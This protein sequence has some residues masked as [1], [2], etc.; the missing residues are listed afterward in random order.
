MASSNQ[1]D[2]MQDP[3]QQPMPEEFTT[4]EVWLHPS[5]WYAKMRENNPVRY[6]PDRDR[7]D[8]FRYADVNNILRDHEK[9]APT[10]GD[11]NG[12]K[13]MVSE[14]PPEH[15]RL[16]TFASEWFQPRTLREYRPRFEE[17]A[18]EI[19]DDIEPGTV[20]IVSEYTHPYPVIVIAESLGLPVEDYDQ[21]MQWS[22]D[23]LRVPART[24]DE[25]LATRKEQAQAKQEMSQYFS[26]LITQRMNGDGNDNDL[27]TITAMN[28]ELTHEEKVAFCIGILVAGNVTTI[29][30]ITS[31]LWCFAE[32]DLFDDIRSGA[33][34]RTQAIEEVLR[35][36]SP[37]QA[38]TRVT[39]KPVE[40]AGQ[41]IDEGEHVVAWAG[42]ANFDPEVFDAPD[43]FR[44]ERKPN[45]HLAFGGGIH[46]CL[47]A[48]LARAEADVALE[49]LLNRFE[50]IA[51]DLSDPSA[52]PI[53]Y[54]LKSL[55]CYLE[56]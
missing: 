24:E 39:R 56:K 43:E 34:D 40:I 54:G 10:H 29:N 4:N 31:A 35:Y 17:I 38:L 6:D 8:V 53:P 33:I 26:E 19:L 27:I 13:T 14:T 48:P 20:E 7:W 21:F 41:E 55:P 49:R 12:P 46:I 25:E 2:V 50:V 11:P 9:F 30:L 52:Q 51:P 18:D 47:G 37:A 15:G 1:N 22:D 23:F 44:P 42:S 32:F 45:R 5:D 28:D 36:R 16:R 3:L